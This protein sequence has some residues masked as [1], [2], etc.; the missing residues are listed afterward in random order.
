MN[1]LRLDG[2]AATC[3]TNERNATAGINSVLLLYVT[4]DPRAIPTLR[5]VAGTGYVLLRSAQSFRLRYIIYP[6]RRRLYVTGR[7]IVLYSAR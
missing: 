4:Y 1:R 5:S 6:I 3:T 2:M 7:W